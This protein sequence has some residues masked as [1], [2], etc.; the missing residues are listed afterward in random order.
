MLIG[1]IVCT[2]WERLHTDWYCCSFFSWSRYTDKYPKNKLANTNIAKDTNTN[3]TLNS[4]GYSSLGKRTICLLIKRFTVFLFPCT[5]QPSKIAIHNS[6]KQPTDSKINSLHCWTVS[7]N[8]KVGSILAKKKKT[9]SCIYEDCFSKWLSK[10]LPEN[11][12]EFISDISPLMFTIALWHFTS[13]SR[14]Y[15]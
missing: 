2:C 6:E 13:N 11:H 5:Y 1:L 8:F 3:E 14:S 7:V 10:A 9:T 4:V 15:Q 12:W